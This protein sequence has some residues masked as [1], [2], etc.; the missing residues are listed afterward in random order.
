MNKIVSKDWYTSKRDELDT[1]KREI[2]E[3]G[4]KKVFNIYRNFKGPPTKREYFSGWDGPYD[5]IEYL[6]QF[7][8]LKRVLTLKN[9]GDMS[10]DMIV[11]YR[12]MSIDDIENELNRITKETENK[13]DDKNE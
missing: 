6:S 11:G 4:E 9:F 12:I 5:V 2:A 7:T 1:L 10:L 3:K 8:P 13:K